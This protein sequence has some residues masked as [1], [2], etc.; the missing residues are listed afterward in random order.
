MLKGLYFTTVVFS[1][2]FRHLIS[3]VTE[4]ISTKLEHIFTYDCYLKKIWFKLSRGFTPPPLPPRAGGGKT[5]FSGTNSELWPN[6]SL[7]WNN[8]STIGK[9][10]VN[11]LGFSSPT[12]PPNLANFGPDTAENGEFLPTP[13]VK[14]SHWETLPALLRR[15]YITD[16]RQTLA[17]VM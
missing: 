4:R 16:S 12:C 11:L 6:I 3:K 14:F 10:L 1:F 7:R 2:F 8:I 9:K 17:R 15:R 13:T 5:I